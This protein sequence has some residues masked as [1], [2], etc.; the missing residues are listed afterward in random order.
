M[1][2]VANRIYVKPEYAEAFEQTKQINMPR[3]PKLYLC[4]A[5][6]AGQLG[7]RDDARRALEALLRL[8]ASSHDD[9]YVRRAFTFWHWREEDIDHHVEGVRKARAL[10]AGET[11]ESP[12]TP[13]RASIAVLPFADLSAEKNQDWFCDGIAEEIL[14]A[15]AHLPGLRVAGRTSS[16]SFR[17]RDDAAKA[18]AERLGVSSVLEGSVRRAGDRVRVTVQL[19]DPANGFQLWSERY[20]R[21]LKDIFAIQDEIARSVGARLKVALDSGMERRLIAAALERTRG[22]KTRAAELLELSSRALLYK[23]RDYEL[24]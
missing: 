23:I 15:L 3:F 9:G 12:R 10:V 21:E 16:F 24:E 17:D 1:I 4:L 19:V 14:N 7:L 13:S 18:I 5:A 11:G 2:T 8:D 20:D 6:A 22:N